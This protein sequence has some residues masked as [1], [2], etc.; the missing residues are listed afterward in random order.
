MHRVF[1]AHNVR[2][3]FT[4]R[5]RIVDFQCE[6][7][8]SKV[9]GGAYYLMSLT[10]TC[11]RRHEESSRKWAGRRELELATIPRREGF[12]VLLERKPDI[13]L[14]YGDVNSTVAAARL[15]APHHFRCLPVMA[16]GAHL[17][18]YIWIRYAKLRKKNVRQSRVIMLSGMDQSLHGIG[19]L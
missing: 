2:P 19:P 10:S 18:I 1:R 9:P 15:K 14:V 4:T 11:H 5:D 12:S 7:K 6:L 13:V 16:A 8:L 3:N 17:K